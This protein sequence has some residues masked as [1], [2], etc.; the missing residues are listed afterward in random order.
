MLRESWT[1]LQPLLAWK[2]RNSGLGVQLGLQPHVLSLWLFLL[3]GLN[4]NPSFHR[5]DAVLRVAVEAE[6]AVSYN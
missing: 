4:E 1:L 5:A 2:W 6:V 3:S